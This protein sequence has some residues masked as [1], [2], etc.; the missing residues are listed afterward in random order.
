[1]AHRPMAKS[2]TRWSPAASAPLNCLSPFHSLL[3]LFFAGKCKKYQG[4]A[5]THTKN[6]KFYNPRDEPVALQKWSW[7]HQGVFNDTDGS[8]LANSL[9]S[10]LKEQAQAAQI[11]L[12]PGSSWHSAVNNDLFD[13]SQCIVVNSANPDRGVFSDNGGRGIDF[14]CLF[15][16]LTLSINFQVLFVESLLFSGVS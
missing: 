15:L 13:P 2:F 12:G 9:S 7:G 3:I 8:L 5:T 1:M 10:A 16:I 11:T 4:G 6:I 14:K